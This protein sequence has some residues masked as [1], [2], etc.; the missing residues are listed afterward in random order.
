MKVVRK[1]RRGPLVNVAI[2]VTI[3]AVCFLLGLFA[4]RML[5]GRVID[6]GGVVDEAADEGSGED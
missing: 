2:A 3:A 4:A 1:S 5:Q 6:D